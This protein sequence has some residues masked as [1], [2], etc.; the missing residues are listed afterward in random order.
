MSEVALWAWSL[1]NSLVKWRNRSRI[2]EG[3]KRV[4]MLG[5]A[6]AVV[7]RND[8]IADVC[9]G[10]AAGWRA[11]GRAKESI[12]WKPLIQISAVT[13]LFQITL[14]MH[15]DSLSCSNQVIAPPLS[16]S[17]P[18]LPV[19]SSRA[20]SAWLP[21]GCR[22]KDRD[23]SRVTEAPRGVLSTRLCGGQRNGVS[24]SEGRGRRGTDGST[25]CPQLLTRRCGGG[26][27]RGL[28]KPHL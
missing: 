1:Q 17:P 21:C 24:P 28:W 5:S 26:G 4:W 10:A 18:I 25:E 11:R 12:F 14:H 2:E 13:L 20:N 8:A 19:S 9:Q 27:G 23:D 16:A 15:L 6:A 3:V 7:T 22:N